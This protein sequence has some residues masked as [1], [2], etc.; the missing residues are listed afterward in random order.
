MVKNETLT[1]K[2]LARRHLTPPGARRAYSRCPLIQ[3]K[4]TEP[5]APVNGHPNLRLIFPGKG[6]SALIALHAFDKGVQA[7]VEGGG[8]FAVGEVA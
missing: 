8:V 7:G 2:S 5:F 3:G 1:P 4:T 6:R